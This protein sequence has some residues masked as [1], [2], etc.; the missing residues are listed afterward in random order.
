MKELEQQK[1]E[2]EEMRKELTLHSSPLPFP[3]SN[4][5]LPSIAGTQTQQTHS[6][7]FSTTISTA[8][9]SPQ[10]S[11]ASAESPQVSLASAESPQVSLASA[12]SLQGLLAPISPLLALADPLVSQISPVNNLNPSE[13]KGNH[14]ILQAK[15]QEKGISNNIDIVKNGKQLREMT[16]DLLITV[17]MEVTPLLFTL[18]QSKQ[19]SKNFTAI[20]QEKFQTVQPNEAFWKFLGD[21]CREKAR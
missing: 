13:K 19:N 10:V 7:S 17:Q 5:S 12:K 9:E 20:F 6:L 11:L 14:A 21:L 15:F 1:K 2:M 4:S 18:P 8:I 3:S 16:I